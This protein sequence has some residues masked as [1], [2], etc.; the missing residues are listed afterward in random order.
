MFAVV[1][2]TYRHG[3]CVEPLRASGQLESDNSAKI[4]LRFTDHPRAF[5]R[6][7]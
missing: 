3:Q 5:L 7:A 4:Q 2:G 6:G 1:Y